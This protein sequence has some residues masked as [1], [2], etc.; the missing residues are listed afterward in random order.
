METWLPL[1][2][3]WATPIGQMLAMV[4]TVCGTLFLLYKKCK[5]IK[6]LFELPTL[7]Q[8]MREENQVHFT[9]H[10]Q[11]LQEI[12]TQN[13]KQDANQLKLVHSQILTIYERG[14]DNGHKISDDDFRHACE[15]YEI[16]GNSDYIASIFRLI[17]K[18]HTGE[19]R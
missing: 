11:Q 16:N 10:D 14:R 5:P 9:Q 19:E 4:G 1:F 12:I 17:T 8:Q 6:Q 3:A 2:L 13:K 18:W 15:L 7:I